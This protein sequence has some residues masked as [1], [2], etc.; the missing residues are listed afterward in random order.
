MGSL[1]LA[2]YYFIPKQHYCTLNNALHASVNIKLIFLMKRL[3]LEDFT[4]QSK[5]S[6][7]GGECFLL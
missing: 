2:L 4:F 3:T 1:N 5:I 7:E 6:H